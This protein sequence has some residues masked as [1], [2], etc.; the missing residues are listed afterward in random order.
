MWVPVEMREEYQDVPNVGGFFGGRIEATARYAGFRRF[1]V[2]T[3]E[4]ARLPPDEPA[5]PR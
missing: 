5:A 3:E 2:S 4:E 1:T